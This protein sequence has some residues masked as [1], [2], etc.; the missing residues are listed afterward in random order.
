MVVELVPVLADE[1]L[2]ATFAALD[3]DDDDDG[4]EEPEETL[5][6]GPTRLHRKPWHDLGGG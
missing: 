1:A 4:A 6:L 5:L 3:E 2:E